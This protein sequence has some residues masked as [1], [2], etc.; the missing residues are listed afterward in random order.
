MYAA[1]IEPALVPATLIQSVQPRL[2]NSI[3]A[4]TSAMPLTPPP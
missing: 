2:P 4:P 3:N 1:M